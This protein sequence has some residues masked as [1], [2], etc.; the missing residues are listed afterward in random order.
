MLPHPPHRRGFTL[1]ELLVV[2]GIIALL[3]S[4]LL[5]ALGRARESAKTTLCASNLR[6]IGQAVTQYTNAHKGVLPVGIIGWGMPNYPNGDHWANILVRSGFASAPNAVKDP[7]FT[8]ASIFMCPNSRDVWDVTGWGKTSRRDGRHF[9]YWN[10]SDV[11]WSTVAPAKEVEV[12]GVSVRWSYLINAGNYASAPLA[13]WS[14][15]ADP[16]PV[17]RITRI[18][19]AAAMA[20]KPP[21]ASS[22][23]PSTTPSSPGPA[24]RSSPGSTNRSLAA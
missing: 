16:F 23:A 8:T 2:I 12:D 18:R 15:A 5:P 24:R 14:N 3:I 21:P 20:L 9:T 11:A 7:A 22:R 13:Y 10:Q 4:I 19:R 1:V 17:K 6:Q